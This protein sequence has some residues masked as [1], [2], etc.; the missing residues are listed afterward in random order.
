MRPLPPSAAEA[1]ERLLAGNTLALAGS[2]LSV[3]EAARREALATGQKPF[4]AIVSCVDSRVIPELVLHAEPGSVIVVR[5]P[6]NALCEASVAAVDFAVGMLGVPLVFVLGHSDCG[7]MAMAVAALTEKGAPRGLPAVVRTLK[8]AVKRT[9]EERDHVNAA[10]AEN[11]R[12]VSAGLARHSRALRSAV[13]AN[14]AGVA[15]GVFDIRSG[16]VTRLL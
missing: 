9:S 14:A 10:I 4:A 5:V 15:G 7:A 13:K 12:L 6:G 3:P 2:P 1:L 11:V 8:R 16:A